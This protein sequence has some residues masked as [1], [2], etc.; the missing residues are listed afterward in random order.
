MTTEISVYS[1]VLERALALDCNA[2]TEIALLPRNFETAGSKEEFLHEDSVSTVRTLWR[3][4]GIIETRLEKEGERFPYIQENAVDWIGPTI[5]VSASFLSGNPNAIAV[6]LGVV[7]N[8][9]T[10]MFKGVM[11]STTVKFDVVK[12]QG[13]TENNQ[14]SYLKFR[15]K[16]DVDGLR[17]LPSII[18]A[19]N[20]NE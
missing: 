10:E 11:G 3:Q 6:A 15:Y 2:P 7:S 5:F 14:R 16:G 4:A 18:R 8:Y 17:E 1:D 20:H 19:V 13:D 12:E 9:L